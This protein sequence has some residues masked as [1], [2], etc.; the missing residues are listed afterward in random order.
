MEY[1]IGYDLNFHRA[2]EKFTLENKWLIF[3]S[4]VYDK[5]L[6]K[7]KDSNY[8]LKDG[9]VVYLSSTSV[10]SILPIN[11]IENYCTHKGIKIKIVHNIEESN[12]IVLDTN[13]SIANIKY[14]TK[15]DMITYPIGMFHKYLEDYT[16]FEKAF[17]VLQKDFY[18]HYSKYISEKDELKEISGYII[19]MFTDSETKQQITNYEPLLSLYHSIEYNKP[20]ISILNL[21]YKVHESSIIIT[22]DLFVSLKQMLI[23]PDETNQ[24][25]AVNIISDANR[26]E[27]IKYIISLYVIHVNIFD[28]KNIISLQ[29]VTEFK[30]FISRILESPINTH[31]AEK[32]LETLKI[33]NKEIKKLL[34]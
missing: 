34:T 10:Y 3:E 29:N 18:K 12:V 20:I 28:K 15:V 32:Y 31:N 30:K 8:D 22:D 16:L 25:L 23:S 13:E 14:A 21:I 27:N 4:S 11:K 5:L 19:Y 7:T 9:D 26:T 1:I 17:I 2:K 24:L 6:N 33:P